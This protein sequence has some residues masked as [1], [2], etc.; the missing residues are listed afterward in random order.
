MDLDADDSDSP[1]IV[2]SSAAH[3]RSFFSTVHSSANRNTGRD[4]SN[5]DSLPP[6][7]ISE[8]RET[9]EIAPSDCDESNRDS[10][11]PEDSTGSEERET[12]EVA[13]SEC[14]ED[15]RDSLPP[16]GSSEE[17]ETPEIA[18][19]NKNNTARQDASISEVAVDPDIETADIETS[20]AELVSKTGSCRKPEVPSTRAYFLS[21][22]TTLHSPSPSQTVE[23]QQAA[24]K[25]GVFG[26]SP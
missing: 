11:P 4:E 3:S 9:P 2:L 18:P 14:D 24:R 8:K 15:S 17:R 22:W 19:S 13:P 10:T 23:I 5:R 21:I 26:R 7:A 12:P 20:A 25:R 16:E 1:D 6:E